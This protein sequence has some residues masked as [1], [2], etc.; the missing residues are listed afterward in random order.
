MQ[1][2]FNP[3]I[4]SRIYAYTN[5]AAYEAYHFN[6][7]K[8]LKLN[9]FLNEFSPSYDFPENKE[10]DQNFAMFTAF[11]Q[12]AYN[13][14][15]RDF[16][17]DS[18]IVVHKEY[19]KKNLDKEVYAN[20]EKL[21]EAVANE[22][23][24]YSKSDNYFKTRSYPLYQPTK[25]LGAWEPTPPQYGTAE[26]PYWAEVR[27]F[28]I[29]IVDSFKAQKHIL[30]DTTSSSEF[31]KMNEKVYRSATDAGE[32]GKVIA[33]FWDGAPN[34]P[35]RVKH[36]VLTK[37]QLNPVAHWIAIGNTLNRLTGKTEGEAVETY[38]RVSLACADAMIV[39]WKNKYDYN[40]IRPHTYINRYIDPSWNPILTT[41]THPEY[42]AGHSTVAGAA[43]TVLVDIFGDIAFTDSTQLKFGHLPRKFKSITHAASECSQS[44]IYGGIHY[45]PSG[46]E[47][48]RLGQRV[49]KL[50]GKLAFS[51][52]PETET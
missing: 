19:F 47:G 7:P 25:Q 12:T 43:S 24:R 38:M 11:Y 8:K 27:P 3:C 1:D 13:F 36:M 15:Y 46:N 40:L 31:Y 29:S 35:N 34:P 21:G 41:P 48:L 28:L 20:S 32:E 45:Q 2:G 6:E 18:F 52:K 4:S 26:E 30:F 44:R 22:I 51:T 17:I 50:Q 16:I 9:A 39:C 23:T 10:I 33:L 14:V 5:L 37:R 42:P 49:A